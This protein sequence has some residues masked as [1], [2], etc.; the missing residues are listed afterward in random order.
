MPV[1]VETQQMG[2]YRLTYGEYFVYRVQHKVFK[3]S[4]LKRNTNDE[5]NVHKKFGLIPLLCP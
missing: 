4:V 2:L 5:Q 3:L 1:D